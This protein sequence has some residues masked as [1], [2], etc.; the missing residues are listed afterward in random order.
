MSITYLQAIHPSRRQALRA[1][2]ASF[3]GCG[4]SGWLPALADATAADKKARHCILLWMSGGPSQIDTFDPKPGHPNGGPFQP[5]ATKAAGVRISE[6]LPK[7]AARSEHLAILR[8]LSTR[9]GDHGRGT[10][11]MHTGRQPDPLVRFSTLGSLVSKELLEQENA[12]PGFVA[13]NPSLGANPSA[14]EPG[15]LGPQFAPLIVKPQPPRDAAGFVEFGVDHLRPAAAVAPVRAT[16]RLQLLQSFQSSP[17]EPARGADLAHRT[18]LRRALQLM[19]SDAGKVFD[20]SLEP[21]AVREKYGRGTFGQSCLA[22]RRLVE[23][24]VSFVEISLGDGGRWD[25]HSNNFDVV[26]E[27]SAELDAGW[28]ALLDDL[29]ARG[30]LETTTIVWM[31]EFGRTPQINGSGGRDHFPA[32]WSAVLAGGGIRGGQAHG[33]TSADGMTVEDG[34]LNEADLIAT[35]CVAIGIDHRRQNIS[36]IGRPFRIADGNPVKQVLA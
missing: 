23:Q 26:R 8:G 35:V 31:G 16:E 32:A 36:E 10:F 13:V 12:L 1:L 20:L 19:N 7:L 4:M 15:F 9:E 25:T 11:T 27:L 29:A 28:S 2:V 14:F 34:K 17:A 3:A 33:R 24:G 30:L 5:I 21:A 6:H 22:A 18:M